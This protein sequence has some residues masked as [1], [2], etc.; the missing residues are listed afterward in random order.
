MPKHKIKR[1]GDNLVGNNNQLTKKRCKKPLVQL[2]INGV[3]ATYIC[4]DGH[5]YLGSQTSIKNHKNY[6]LNLSKL[7]EARDMNLPDV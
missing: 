2:A 5:F 6:P 1:C 3:V 7:I 4:E